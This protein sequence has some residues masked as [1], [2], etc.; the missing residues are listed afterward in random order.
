MTTVKDIYDFIDSFA[1]FATAMD[2]DNSGIL[3]GDRNAPVNTAV[4]ALD[5][6][7]AVIEEAVETKAQLII[8]HHPIIF[9]PLRTLPYDSP[10]ALLIKNGLSALCAHTNLDLSTKGVN[11]CLAN[12]LA[13]QDVRL[14]EN[15]CIAVG[16]LSKTIDAKSFALYVRKSLSCNGVRFIGL[17]KAIKTVAVSS[18]AGGDS[19]YRCKELHADAL[20]TGEIKHHQLLDAYRMNVAVVDAGHFCTE[21]VVI[22]PLV[23]MLQKKFRSVNFIE[24]KHCTDAVEYV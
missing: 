2:F 9:Q 21:N 22:K 16:T 19:L 20:V 12:A 1:P 6:T 11:V 24:S 7:P 8:S 14:I 13:L 15:E 5:I 4:A 18:G 23:Q 17:R 10:A 3:A